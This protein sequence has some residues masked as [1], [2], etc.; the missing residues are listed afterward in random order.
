M[1]HHLHR[2]PGGVGGELARGQ[3]I[4]SHPVL[5][6]PDRVLDLG[7]APMVGFEFESLAITV[8]DEGVVVVDGKEGELGPRY[9]GHPAD[10]EP[11]ALR[12]F[13]VRERGV[14]RLGHVGTAVDPVRDRG[15]V[16]L[17]D[18]LDEPTHIRLLADRDGETDAK[19]PAGRDDV[20]DIEATVGS[21]RELSGGSCVP[22]PADCLGQEVGGAPSRFGPALAQAGHQDVAGAGSDSE[23]GMI[24]A[25]LGIPVVARTLLGEA[26]CLADRRVEID[27]KRL[28]LRSGPGSPGPSQQFPTD[29]IELTGMA[30]SKAAQE[31]AQ[32]RGSLEGKAE[33]SLGPAGSEHVCV[34]D[35]VAA[36]ERRHD[37]AQEFVPDVRPT[38]RAAEVEMALDQPF[39]TQL[40]GPGGR[41]KKPGVGHQRSSS[42][43]VSTRS[44]LCEDR[45]YWVLP[46]LGVMGV[47]NAI[48][49]MIKRLRDISVAGIILGEP[50]LSGAVDFAKALEAA[51]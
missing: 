10:D 34:V 14:R 30:P 45:I 51:A 8:G 16:G 37:E 26:V 25:H 17:G 50:L 9:R 6:I 42:K 49:P 32:S 38:D 20:V 27:R 31:R 12:I 29:R 23:E 1:G 7:M 47:L 48:F 13:L 15:P 35:T 36:R 21:H 3:V 46:L 11:E 5:E 18:G 2:E 41:Q 43:A 4:E 39:Q 44:R 28:G 24:T 33:D 19:L 22:G 40:V